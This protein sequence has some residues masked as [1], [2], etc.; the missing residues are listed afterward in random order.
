MSCLCTSSSESLRLTISWTNS[1]RKCYFS[2]TQIRQ[3]IECKQKWNEPKKWN[4]GFQQFLDFTE[5][6]VTFLTNII[7]SSSSVLDADRQKLWRT[8][9]GNLVGPI[10]HH[11]SCIQLSKS[12][13][14]C[15]RMNHDIQ[16]L[17]IHVSQIVSWIH[18]E[19]FAMYFKYFSQSILNI[20]ANEPKNEAAVNFV[21]SNQKPAF[22]N[23]TEVSFR[24]STHP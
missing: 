6:I 1:A 24:Q 20:T 18:V 14:Q 3:K 23:G 5:F 12:K 10:Q 21:K 16:Y 19:Y 22:A 8:S 11:F 15:K 7:L 17:K 13:T 4:H 2:F 9:A